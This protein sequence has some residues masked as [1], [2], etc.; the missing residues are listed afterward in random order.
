MSK[1]NIIEI[2]DW[3]F[4]IKSRY[5]ERCNH[6]KPIMDSVGQTI[7]C[8][9]CNLQLD[10]FWVL[11]RALVDLRSVRKSLERSRELLVKEWEDFNKK[12]RFL[13]VIKEVERAW[14]GSNKM[15]VCCP[16]C[17]AG[18][19]PED[20]LGDSKISSEIELEQRKFRKGK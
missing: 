1:D 2:E 10:A 15:A 13:K 12:H 8:S 18:I 3:K 19:L 14:R 16:H 5:E 17:H 11:E 9:D 4:E 6:L 7:V 20:G